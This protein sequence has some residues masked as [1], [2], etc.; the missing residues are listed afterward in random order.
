MLRTSFF[1]GLL[2]ERAA[3]IRSGVT[4][5]AGVDVNE[6]TALRF[7][8]VFASIRVIS[9]TKGSLPIEVFEVSGTK[10][11]RTHSHPV[12]EV[13][14]NEPNLD[15]TPMVWS[16]TRQAHILTHGNNFAEITWTNDGDVH[17]LTPHH[18]STVE[19]TRGDDNRLK[20]T[21]RQAGGGTRT[22]DRDDM[23]H[24]PGLGGNGIIGWSPIRLAAES[25]GIGIAQERFGGLYFANGARPSLIVKS[26][27]KLED[28][29]F[30]SLQ[31]SLN[32]NYSGS[33]AHKA[34]LLEGGL[35]AQSM[36][37]PLNEAQFLESREY[38]GE[39]IACRWFRLP[40]HVVGYLRRAT[41]S[42][43]EQQDLY[44]EKHTM[45][46]WLERDEQELKRKLFPRREWHRFKIK[47]NVNALLSADIKT[48][49]EAHRS[50]IMAGWKSR[51]EV[52]R[53]ENMNPEDGLDDF[54]LPEAIFGKTG[55]AAFPEKSTDSTDSKRS[56]PRLQVMLTRTLTGLIHRELTLA[57]RSAGKPVEEFKEKIDKFYSQ[58]RSTVREKLDGVI[59][60]SQ[61]AAIEQ[62]LD[63]HKASL[64]EAGPQRCSDACQSWT[65]GI[66]RLAAQL[67][68]Q[69]E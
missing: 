69:S 41:F 62:T 21:I 7:A 63:S 30:A 9:E 44:F 58:H 18:P 25:I 4:G 48:R 60:P 27:R 20:Y 24:V 53:L 51:N 68:E 29:E 32:S 57:S 34:L 14:G 12:A 55:D 37:I 64:I 23:L 43:I 16:E 56:D 52:R 6:K 36:A 17:S 13:L 26:D 35:E 42:N 8:A 38:Q 59:A 33:D 61:L 66:D 50:A 46:P 1:S 15:H 65:D 19:V 54:P 3:V 31:N 47:T 22:V 11:V 5:S 10:Q 28:K 39:E 40:P 49:Y 45:R 2:K 67:L